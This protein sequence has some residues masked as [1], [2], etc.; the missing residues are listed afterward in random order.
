[1]DTPSPESRLQLTPTA[2]ALHEEQAKRRDL[3]RLQQFTDELSDLLLAYDDHRRQIKLLL[4]IHG[5]LVLLI[6]LLAVVGNHHHTINTI[7]LVYVWLFLA[8]AFAVTVFGVSTTRAW[9]PRFF[10]SAMFAVSAG[11]LVVIAYAVRTQLNMQMWY[12]ILLLALQAIDMGITLLYIWS[13]DQVA[14][15]G[16]AA[17]AKVVEIDHSGLAVSP[18]ASHT[19]TAIAMNEQVLRGKWTTRLNSWLQRLVAPRVGRAHED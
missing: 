16:G 1:M 14:G 8:F 18:L 10:G 6:F 5:P 4:W 12:D 19:R 7:A 3:A 15:A 9:M 13:A 2:L 17:S 11:S